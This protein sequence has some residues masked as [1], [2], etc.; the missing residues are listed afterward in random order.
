MKGI[1]IFLILVSLSS[2][3][4]E[5]PTNSV[6]NTSSGGGTTDDSGDSSTGIGNCTSKSFGSG[7]PDWI[8]DNFNCVQ[9]TVVGTNYQF[10]SNDIPEH[11]SAYFPT[12][13][14]RY[15]SS[16]PVG[17]AVNP[18][19]ISEQS[20]TFTIPI[21]PVF[22]GGTATSFDAIGVATDGIV[23]YNNEAAP[24]DTLAAEIATLD[25]ANAHPTN[26]GSYHYHI[27]PL[28]ITNDDSKIIGILRDGYTVFG[29]KCP[30]TN[31]YPGNNGDALDSFNGHTAETGITGLGIVYHYH[32][33]DIA[34]DDGDGVSEP[35][36][37]DTYRGTPGSMVSN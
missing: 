1:P 12:T 7:V 8:S 11:N 30:A 21:T 22:G 25:N 2:C 6:R 35:V 34:S 33:F 13:D 14:S 15:E 17:R 3:N 9:V 16:M 32:V 18:N 29:R 28:K 37:T 23:F 26:T 24:G 5:A 36:I 19:Q 31:D 4:F 20:Y 10:V 27:E